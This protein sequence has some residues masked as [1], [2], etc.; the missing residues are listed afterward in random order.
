MSRIPFGQVVLAVALGIAS[1]VYIFQPYFV[2]G[3]EQI[4]QELTQQNKIDSTVGSQQTK[5][6]DQT[7]E[8]KGSSQLGQQTKKE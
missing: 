4:P 5:Q 3:D 8:V 6:H 7:D 2:K 1:G